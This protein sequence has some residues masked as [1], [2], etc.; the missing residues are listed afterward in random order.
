MNY[1]ECVA[2]GIDAG[3]VAKH[4]KALEKLM[5]AMAV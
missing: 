1:A 4:Q 2:V 3:K 5:K